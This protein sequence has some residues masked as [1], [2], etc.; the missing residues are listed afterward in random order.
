MPRARCR[1]QTGLGT[2]TGSILVL[3]MASPFIPSG[4]W[5]LDCDGLLEDGLKAAEG[6]ERLAFVSQDCLFPREQSF[7]KYRH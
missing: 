7:C 1:V 2:L 3:G 6:L 4:I 5:A